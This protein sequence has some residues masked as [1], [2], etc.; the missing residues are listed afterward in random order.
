MQFDYEYLCQN[1]GHLTGVPTRLYRAGALVDRFAPVPFEPDP[2]SLVLERVRQAR[3]ALSYVDTAEFLMYGAVRVDR[4]DVL[5]LI[6]PTSQIRPTRAQAAAVL[7]ALGEPFGRIDELLPY[8]ASSPGYP[9]ENFLQILCFVHYAL[10]GE[11]VP[12][13]DLLRQDLHFA[14]PRLSAE[15]SP[16]S[17]GGPAAPAVGDD[18]SLHNT[19]ELERTLLSCVSAGNLVALE[20]LFAV[21]TAGRPGKMA[22]DE[23]RQRKNTFICVTTLATRAAISGGLPTEEAFSLS[24]VHIQKA[25]LV[26]DPPEIALLTMEM[27]LDYTRRVAQLRLG[28]SRTK[29]SVAV[30]RHVQQNLHRNLTVA[31]VARELGMNRSHLGERFRADTGVPLGT[32]L[33]QQKM[34]EA[35]RLLRTTDQSVA[36]IS[37]ALAFSS[38]SYFQNVFRKSVGCTPRTYRERETR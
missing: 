7:R 2:A 30:L 15:P 18:V 4:D 25:E 24:D 37:D 29:L 14:R 9:L 3:H 23:L 5:L 1:L 26:S 34:E 27:L 11:K 35:K 19:Y 17:P 10:N 36:S 33:T 6:G 8:F 31:D 13:G 20:R 32:F 22:H 12:V 28:E 16:A 38:Q 21:P